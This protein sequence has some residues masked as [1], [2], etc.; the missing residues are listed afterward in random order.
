MDKLESLK[1]KFGIEKLDYKFRDDAVM[2]FGNKVYVAKTHSLII[3]TYIKNF[4]LKLPHAYVHKIDHNYFIDVNK[5]LLTMPI[6]DVKKCIE[7]FDK[8]AVVYKY[9]YN[10]GIVKI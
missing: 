7:D 8:N 1:D 4:S 2:V 9:Y 5:I 3:R 6:T 10:H